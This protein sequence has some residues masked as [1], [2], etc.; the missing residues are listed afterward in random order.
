MIEPLT[1][2]G[3]IV[4][5]CSAASK[6]T[7]DFSKLIIAIKNVPKEVTQVSNEIVAL[8]ATLSSLQ[9]RFNP[10]STGYSDEQLSTINTVVDNTK[11]TL[12]ELTKLVEQASAGEKKCL[13]LWRKVGFIWNADE[14]TSYRSGLIAYT[15]MLNLLT[16]TLAE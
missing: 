12:I 7:I 5:A 8:S 2:F 14:I 15:T 16:A 13:G 6:L 11:E 10:L 4:G 9:Q 1:L 3:G